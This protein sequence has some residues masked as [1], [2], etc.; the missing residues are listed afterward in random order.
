[1]CICPH[2]IKKYQKYYFSQ[3][4]LNINFSYDARLYLSSLD[5][6]NEWKG[7]T[8]Q[9]EEEESAEDLAEKLEEELCEEQ[10]YMDF[11]AALKNDEIDGKLN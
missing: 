9:N 8:K 1:M 11:Y 5:E 10:R 4:N 7:K 3:K 2:F 6:F